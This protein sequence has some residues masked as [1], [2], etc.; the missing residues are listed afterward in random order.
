MYNL[1]TKE[2]D[3]RGCFILKSIVLPDL[4]IVTEC[5]HDITLM[6]LGGRSASH[7]WFS[8][9]NFYRKLWA[10]DSGADLCHDAGIVPDRLVGDGDSASPE[11][12]QWAEDHG[13]Q[14][15]KYSEDKDLTD[16]QLAL[17]LFAKDPEKGIG[18]LFLTGCFAGRFDHLWSTVIS[19]VNC[20]KD[21][22]PLGMADEMEGLFF[23]N[24][25]GSA[26]FIFKR[27]PGA[28]SLISLSPQSRGVSLRGTKW[29]LSDETLCYERP[30]SISN[31]LK[32]GSRARVSLN[33]G[34]LGVYWVWNA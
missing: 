27:Q 5:S 25:P 9:L 32:K 34:K 21:V 29:Q 8:S 3:R 6:V 10:I 24:G 23:I 2:S 22:V 14:I 20:G 17:E 4:E 18:H 19:F 7:S 28:L 15:S 30:Y 11:A 31:R 12:W 33:E 26:E 1:L 13:S 16:F